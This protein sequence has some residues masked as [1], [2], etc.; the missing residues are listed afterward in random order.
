MHSIISD[1]VIIEVVEAWFIS[2]RNQLTVHPYNIQLA[3]ERFNAAFTVMICVINE[4]DLIQHIVTYIL[5]VYPTVTLAY[6]IHSGNQQSLSQRS[7]KWSFKNIQS[8]CFVVPQ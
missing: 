8:F 6:N 3:S 1:L 5:E 7:F 4:L 2:Q